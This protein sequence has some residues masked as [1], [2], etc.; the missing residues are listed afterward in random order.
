MRHFLTKD[1]EQAVLAAIREA[2][3][4]SRGELRLVVT[5]QWIAD[6]AKHAWKLF[7]A[8]GMDATRERNAAM[9]LVAVRLRRFAVIGDE[10]LN[11]VVAPDYW[12]TIADAM[13]AHLREGRRREA[14]TTGIRMLGETMAAHWPAG[15]ADN[16]DELP[17]EIR[18]E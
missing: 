1:D 2:E 10:G 12:T 7:H 3:G 15:A 18:Y 9:I 8:L 4:R 6:P 14:L 11:A 5:S 16:P 13:A 17:N